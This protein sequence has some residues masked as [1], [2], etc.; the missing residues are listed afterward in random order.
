MQPDAVHG[1]KRSSRLTRHEELR[2]LCDRKVATVSDDNTRTDAIFKLPGFTASTLSYST[3][4]DSLSCGV[5]SVP[6]GH[7]FLKAV[8]SRCIV[9]IAGQSYEKTP[10]S[11]RCRGQ[12]IDLTSC[13]YSVRLSPRRAIP[14]RDDVQQRDPTTGDTL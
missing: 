10:M 14:E 2:R 5:Y 4:S 13:T 3:R 1:K 6:G 12:R 7:I 11:S 8:G 9:G